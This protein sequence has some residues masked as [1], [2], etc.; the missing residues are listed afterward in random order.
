MLSQI[1]NLGGLYGTLA[2]K[3][4][5]A[6]MAYCIVVILSFGM[7]IVSN[8]LAL[9]LNAFMALHSAVTLT[10]GLLGLLAAEGREE[11]VLKCLGLSCRVGEHTVNK[12]SHGLIAN[13]CRRSYPEGIP[14]LHLIFQYAGDVVVFFASVSTVVE[15]VQRLAEPHSASS[16]AAHILATAHIGIISYHY[17]CIMRWSN[18]NDLRNKNPFSSPLPG[19]EVG[20]LLASPFACACGSFASHMFGLGGADVLVSMLLSIYIGQWSG[21]R[22]VSAA[23]ILASRSPLLA[24]PVA[25]AS[26]KSSAFQKALLDVRMVAGVLEIKEYIVWPITATSMG[27]LVRV[28]LSRTSS[29]ESA[30][31]SIRELFA[32]CVDHLIVEC[33]QQAP[34]TFQSFSVPATISQPFTIPAPAFNAPLAAPRLDDYVP[35]TSVPP[36]PFPRTYKASP[37]YLGIPQPPAPPSF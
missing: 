34:Q 27:A 12:S 26:T 29:E 18:G 19:G 20:A 37:G 11:I 30:G 13:A 33:E 2:N 6:A 1:R 23:Y 31:H 21:K 14:R 17:F 28:T 32:G 15:V 4:L 7:S 5:G 35:A 25:T 9:R 10:G 3:A 24:L 16:F 22:L 8:S 36:F